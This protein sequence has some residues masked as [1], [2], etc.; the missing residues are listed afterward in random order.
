MLLFVA[1]QPGILVTLPAVGRSVFMT[2]KTSVHAVFV[3]ALVF[4]LVIHLLR[5]GGYLEGFSASGPWRIP[6]ATVLFPNASSTAKSDWAKY[7]AMLKSPSITLNSVISMYNT[8]N[9]R[10]LTALKNT[11]STTRNADIN[12]YG[13]LLN[14]ITNKRMQ[15]EKKQPVIASSMAKPMVPVM[16][17]S[18]AKPMAPMMSNSMPPPKMSSSSP[19]Y[20]LGSYIYNTMYQPIYS[21]YSNYMYGTVM[22]SSMP[23][24]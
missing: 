7:T 16:S 11:K 4:M 13:M 19:P 15:L 22:S 2:G 14:Q 5:R 10:Y 18:M 1:L 9:S 24:I 8:V 21:M 12:T 20:G 17:N 6:S 23:R 3:H